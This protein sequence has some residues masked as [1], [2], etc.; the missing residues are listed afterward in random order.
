MNSDETHSHLTAEIVSK[1]VSHHKLAP[2]E[3]P[4]LITTVHK[5]IG[6]LGT[7][8]ETEEPRTPAVSVRQS[9]R[10]DYVVCLDCGYRGLVLRRHINVRH[11]L[12]PNEYR[13]R[14][15]LKNNHPLTAPAYSER[16]S[17]VA[18]A[19]GLG[20][21]PASRIMAEKSEAATAPVGS[22]RKSAATSR[23]TLKARGAT[24]S[25][26]AMEPAADSRK[27]ARVRRSRSRRAAS[28]AD[29]PTSPAAEP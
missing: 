15:G 26:E 8:S 20:R 19:L 6:G 27:P 11:G 12:N 22:G 2:T 1:Y 23:P 14:W 9:V 21:K 17:S 7:P 25:A 13:Q 18:K 5:A 4:T 28:Q 24:K 3:L 16:R 10:Q 29:Q